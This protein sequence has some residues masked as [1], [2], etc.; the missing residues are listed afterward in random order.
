MM[1]TNL[2]ISPEELRA[3]QARYQPPAFTFTVIE[4]SKLCDTTGASRPHDS[5]ISILGEETSTLNLSSVYKKLNFDTPSVNISQSSTNKPQPPACSPAFV[6]D[7]YRCSDRLTVK[8]SDA[9]PEVRLDELLTLG[10]ECYGVQKLL[11]VSSTAHVYLLGKVV[12]EDHGEGECGDPLYDPEDATLAMK[13]SGAEGH[14]EFHIVQ[15][16]ARA[17]ALLKERRG[18]YFVDYSRGFVYR[19]KTFLLMRYYDQGTLMDALET[20]K[21]EQK[22]MQEELV[23]FYCIELLKAIELLH[24]FNVVHGNIALENLLIRADGR[25]LSESWHPDGSSGWAAHGLTLIDFRKS[26][27]M[28]QPDGKQ[29]LCGTGELSSGLRACPELRDGHS[30]SF[31]IDTFDVLF[32]VFSLLYASPLN[33]VFANGK[34]SPAC[35]FESC[36]HAALWKE[37]FELFLNTTSA[38]TTPCFLQ[39]ARLRLE[40]YL[41]GQS[42]SSRLGAFIRRQSINIFNLRYLKDQELEDL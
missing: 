35:A 14:W 30:P 17:L 7:L 6:S 37:I 21:R 25:S 42:A 26:L 12:E 1:G 40:V 32:V 3:L 29:G 5:N 18:G 22:K 2:E 19:D 20:Y 31:Q 36:A 34:W 13:V 15:R 11:S 41:K 8:I 39:S 4:P 24:R 9:A 33:I 27:D 28:D 10:R 16:I 23:I 38:K